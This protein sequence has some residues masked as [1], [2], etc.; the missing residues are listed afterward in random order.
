MGT[1]I[2]IF[3]GKS[4]HAVLVAALDWESKHHHNYAELRVHHASTTA[5]VPSGSIA[6]HYILTVV[7]EYT[8]MARA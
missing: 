2:E 6:L 3:E 8:G 5:V 1:R 7:F 4:V